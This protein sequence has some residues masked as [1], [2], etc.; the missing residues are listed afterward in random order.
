MIGLGGVE[1]QDG[2]T[3]WRGVEDNEALAAAIDLAGKRP[4]DGDFLGAGR[5]Q[6]FLEQ[7]QRA[8]VER[9]ARLAHDFLGVSGHFGCRVDAADGNAGNFAVDRSSDVRRRIGGR[10]MHLVPALR[11]R[12][13]DGGSDGGLADA[14]LAHGH[15]DAVAGCCQFV[16]QGAK[17]GGQRG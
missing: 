9:A 7:R 14:A 2:V 4:E 10:Q 5:T 13:G 17:A 12:D 15:D 3:G 16:D 6:V 11:Q 8:G 1:Q